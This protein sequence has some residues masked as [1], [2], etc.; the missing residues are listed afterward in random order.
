MLAYCKLGPSQQNSVKSWIAHR[1][2][3]TTSHSAQFHTPVKFQHRRFTLVQ[4]QMSTF[5]ASMQKQLPKL[6]ADQDQNLAD[7]THFYVGPRF[8]EMKTVNKLSTHS[9]GRLDYPYPAVMWPCPRGSVKCCHRQRF[10]KIMNVSKIGIGFTKRVSLQIFR[11]CVVT[12]PLKGP[13]SHSKMKGI[14]SK[15]N[16]LRK[17]R[18]TVKL[19]TMYRCTKLQSHNTCA[20]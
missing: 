3:C 17:A 6:T 15:R 12:F 20:T 5:A 9:V 13:P 4:L 16:I 8:C 10:T 14:L 7:M 2:F 11:A 1:D 19:S 18:V